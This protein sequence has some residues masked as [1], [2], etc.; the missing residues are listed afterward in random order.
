MQK[1]NSTIISL[2][3]FC[4]SF[5]S[6]KKE[7]NYHPEWEVSTMSGK[8]DG[9]LL[10]C[11]LASAQ[12]YTIGSTTMIQ[13]SGS[14]GN[15]GFT[16]MI[17]NFKGIGTYSIAD[18]NIATYLE[19]N[20]GMQDAYMALSKGT[21]KITSY[22]AD[23]LI[24][25]TF[26]F[27]GE[28][29]AISKTKNITEGQFTISLVPVKI[30]E[31]TNSTNNLN[32]KVDGTPIGFTAQANLISVPIMGNV[33]TII[34]LNG[35]KFLTLAIFDYKG[36]GVYEFKKGMG[37]GDYIQDKTPTGSFTDSENGKITITAATSTTI[38]GTFEFVAP[39][40]DS[41]IKTKKT[42]TEGTFELKYTK[43]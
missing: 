15:I 16:L 43:G 2:I 33:M 22:S 29:T 19:G 20:S 6:C 42:I 24:K 13:I 10:K 8:I 18:S 3:L 14:K 12:T 37:Q 30:P 36:V 31:T 25:G 11:T 4:I 39:N 7:I 9:V 35:D 23:K 32:A 1:V 40:Q 28:N 5:S 17:N 38:K 34:G 26:E 27:E 21:I 41:S